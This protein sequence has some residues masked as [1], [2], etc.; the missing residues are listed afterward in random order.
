MDKAKKMLYAYKFLL[1]ETGG[2]K[3]RLEGNSMFPTLTNGQVV[4]VY[5]IVDDI[6][7]SDIVLFIRKE[8]LILHRVIKQYNNRI[9]LKGDNE[10][11]INVVSRDNIIARYSN[12]EITDN[13][14]KVIKTVCDNSIIMF[15]IDNGILEKIKL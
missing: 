4:S 2:V 13:S 15:I 7:N 14:N 5:P 6:N 12:C 8:M 3:I 11:E 1:K 9:I 10:D